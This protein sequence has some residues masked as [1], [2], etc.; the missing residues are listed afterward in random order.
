MVSG[1]RQSV[2]GK[3]NFTQYIDKEKIYKM[4]ERKCERLDTCIC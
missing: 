2:R 4:L 3:E 1:S